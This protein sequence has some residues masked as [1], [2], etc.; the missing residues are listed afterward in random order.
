M[1]GSVLGR[2]ANLVQKHDKLFVLLCLLLLQV[3]IFG[4]SIKQVGFYLDDWN[5]LNVLSA[6]PQDLFGMM[7][8]YMLNDPKVSIRPV[9]V[10]YQ[11]ILFS[12][13]KLSPL[14]YHLFNAALELLCGW[15]IYVC[16]ARISRSNLL[17][18]LTALFYACYPIHD[19]THYWVLCHAVNLSLALYLASLFC[20][21]RWCSD[22]RNVWLALMFAAFGL[23]IFNYETLLPLSAFTAAC[24]WLERGWKRAAVVFG[25][26]VLAGA[27]L[28]VYQRA[29]VP[30]FAKGWLHQMHVDAGQIS[31]TI[32][33][34]TFI[35][36]PAN[37]IGF[38]VLQSARVVGDLSLK[39]VYALVAIGVLVFGALWLTT[40]SERR[41]AGRSVFEMVLLSAL[42]IIVSFSI[43]GLNSEYAP[44]LVTLVNRINTGAALGWSLLAAVGMVLLIH[45]VPR[46]RTAVAVVS[47]M[48]MLLFCITDWSMA[49]PWVVSWKMQ[50]RI[51]EIA[52]SNRGTLSGAESLILANCP[53]YVMWSPVFDGVWDFQS[54]IQT[55]TGN[56]RIQANVVSERLKV[57]P[58]TVCDL[59]AGFECGK[60]SYNNM[61]VLIPPQG[62]LVPIG[63]ADEFI[64]VVGA[65]SNKFGPEH[66][67]VSDWR[68]NLL[69]LRAKRGAL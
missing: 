39:D 26:H 15:L 19:S 40:Q 3:L 21:L 41:G 8:N 1:F 16:V 69:S 66:S 29:I 13:F 68:N 11:S 60:Y 58:D 50:H 46:C 5:M 20:A 61:Y 17:A 6:G 37:V 57:M 44:T 52:K 43:F 42:L 12:A 9:Q 14:G 7:W 31:K 33:D 53:R 27:G 47:T 18:L 36:A 63:S 35:T 22:S 45:R 2:A 64:D 25:L 67:V 59:Y 32:I 65:A 24:V 38:S 51:M 4:R 49:Q 56:R 23:S 62:D 55:V 48:S 54:M 10:V 28:V 34:G 30:L